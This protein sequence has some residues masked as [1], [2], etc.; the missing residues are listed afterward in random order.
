MPV[1]AGGVG[2]HGQPEVVLY[3]LATFQKLA[4]LHPADVA[5]PAAAA[6]ATAAKAAV[7][8]HE[9]VSGRRALQLRHANSATAGPPFD[10]DDVP[11]SKHSFESYT[12]DIAFAP[13]AAGGHA[14]ILVVTGRN[15]ATMHS[16]ATG[17]E[18]WRHEAAK[19][20]NLLLDLS[21]A[22]SWQACY[23]VLLAGDGTVLSTPASVAASISNISSDGSHGTSS[24]SAAPA[25]SDVAVAPD[26]D[27]VAAAEGHDCIRSVRLSDPGRVA[28]KLQRHTQMLGASEQLHSSKW[29]G[30]TNLAFN[31]SG[32]LRQPQGVGMVPALQSYS[33]DLHSQLL[34]CV[35]LAQCSSSAAHCCD[36]N[37][38]AVYCSTV[39]TGIISPLF[40]HCMALLDAATMELLWAQPHVLQEQQQQADNAAC[41]ARVASLACASRN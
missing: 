26:S 38:V 15:G 24:L 39:A 31:C 11:C 33:S 19:W 14:V 20:G 34:Q 23:Q 18:L 28:L 21:L 40:K 2:S 29:R 6:A 37:M 32:T 12:G 1:D 16:T 17:A 8:V 7:L 22:D 36:S 10:A 41:T 25:Y 30:C 4:E 13:C 3:D 9:L 27:L 35:R 5:A